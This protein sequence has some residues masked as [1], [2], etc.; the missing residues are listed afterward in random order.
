MW[1]SSGACVWYAGRRGLR[2]PPPTL[3]RGGVGV[4]QQVKAETTPHHG[5]GLRIP[6]VLRNSGVSQTPAPA[7]RGAPSGTV[8]PTPPTCAP[9]LH[10]PQGVTGSNYQGSISPGPPHS[11]GG[12]QARPLPGHVAFLHTS[13]WPSVLL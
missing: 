9:C 2:P 3:G 4:L 12:S 10:H 8:C 13:L 6:T 11:W 7:L 5:R 1:V